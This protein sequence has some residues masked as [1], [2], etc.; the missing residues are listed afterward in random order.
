MPRKATDFGAEC[1]GALTAEQWSFLAWVAQE[2]KGVSYFSSPE[3]FGR[4]LMLM[5]RNRLKCVTDGI[6]MQAVGIEVVPEA[7]IEPATKGL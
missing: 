1:L 7:G 2:F 6:S 5:K 3:K 4:S